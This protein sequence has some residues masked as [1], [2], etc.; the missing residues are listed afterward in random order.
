MVFWLIL[1]HLVTCVGPWDEPSHSQ[2]ADATCG[3]AAGSDSACTDL[4]WQNCRPDYGFAANRHSEWGCHAPQPRAGIQ[5]AHRCERPR[6]VRLRTGPARTIHRT[7]STGL[8]VTIDTSPRIQASQE[9]DG[10]RQEWFP[11]ME[12]TLNQRRSSWLLFQMIGVEAH[13]LLPDDQCD[14]GNLP[15]QGQACHRGLPSLGQQ[16]LVKIVERSGSDAGSHRRT[17]ENV[18][19]VVVVVFVETAQGYRSLRAL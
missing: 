19:E 10:H 4:H 2:L 14:H 6:R 18:F 11:G 13:L 3:L 17:F 9:P 7:D 5:A 1:G 16:S 15:R 12:R 8:T